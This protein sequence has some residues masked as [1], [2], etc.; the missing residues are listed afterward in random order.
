VG[1]ARE[2]R[3]GTGVNERVLAVLPQCPSQSLLC[4]RSPPLLRLAQRGG[5]AQRDVDSICFRPPARVK[6]DAVPCADGVP[7]D[8]LAC[9]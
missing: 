8:Q 1:G 5:P 3:D 2:L 9:C 7:C 6:R 4:C